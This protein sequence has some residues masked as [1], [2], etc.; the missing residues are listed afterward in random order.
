MKN[1]FKLAAILA[2]CIPACAFAQ[3]ATFATSKAATVPFTAESVNV[4]E[5]RIQKTKPCRSVRPLPVRT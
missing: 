1:T 5:V 4:R 2:F 3:S